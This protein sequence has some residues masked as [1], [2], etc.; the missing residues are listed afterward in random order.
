MD[1]IDTQDDKIMQKECTIAFAISF[2]ADNEK[3]RS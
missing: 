3:Q 1:G 2:T